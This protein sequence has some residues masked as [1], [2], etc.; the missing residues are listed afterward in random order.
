MKLATSRRS[1]RLAD[2][3]HRELGR[4]LVEDVADPRLNLVTV[5]G[6]RLNSD[7]TLAEVFV[8]Y[9]L[10]T[11]NRE[12]VQK[13]LEKAAGFLRSRLGTNLKL[14]KT[15]ELRFRFDEYLEEMVYDHPHTPE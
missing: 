4:L 1:I 6:V 5:S 14:K 2:E 8:T 15:P 12:T 7:I 10:A 9:D 13:A 3:I 11:H